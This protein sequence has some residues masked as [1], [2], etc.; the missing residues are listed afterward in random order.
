MQKKNIM[1]SLDQLAEGG[2]NEQFTDA[3][4]KVA[5]NILN[6]NTSATA[7]RSLTIKVSFKPS[8]TRQTIETDFKVSTS[9]AGVEV[10]PTV[11]LVGKNG[12]GNVEVSEMN[13]LVV[14]QTT[15]DLE[16]GQILDEHGEPLQGEEPQKVIDFRKKN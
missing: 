9:L 15:V 1:I 8:K 2:L 12:N 16:T 10:E 14:G 6:V 4:E 11:L 13:H 3:M 7:K 5:E